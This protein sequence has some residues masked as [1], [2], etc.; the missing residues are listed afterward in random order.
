MAVYYNEFDPFAAQWLRELIKCGFIADG[1]VDER[2]ITEVK[3]DDLKEFTQCH[4]F[5]GIGGWSYAMR[6]AGVSDDARLWTGSCP[7][8]SFSVAGKQKGV[9]DERHLWP[10]FSKLIDECKP[11][12]VFGEQVETAIK[13]GWLD[14]VQD[15]LEEYGYACASAVLPA[16]S[17]GAPHIRHR[18][19]WGGL[20]HSFDGDTKG[21]RLER[22]AVNRV[23][24]GTEGREVE[25]RHSC[26]SSDADQQLENPDSFGCRG[27]Y[28]QSRLR[29]STERFPINGEEQ[30]FSRFNFWS[31]AEWRLGQDGKIRPVEPGTFPLAYGIPARVGRLRGYGNAIVPQVAAEFIKAFLGAKDDMAFER[32]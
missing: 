8:Q 2:S 14:L 25:G 22:K 31:G 27:R 15:D 17:V 20:R 4:F 32:P 28:S 16:A 11:P 18:L 23:P 1:V 29:T 13:H 30:L 21:I 26:E 7:C 9:D 5:A 19:Y 24:D 10:V 12:V 6:L 3:A